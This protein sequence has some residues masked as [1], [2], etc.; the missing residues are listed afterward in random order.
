MV[1]H[2]SLVGKD[3]LP[4]Q[5]NQKALN[6]I[7]Q[8][9]RIAEQLGIS[10][11]TFRERLTQKIPLDQGNVLNDEAKEEGWSIPEGSKAA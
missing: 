5:E 7:R 11:E 3:G 6:D 4:F 8:Q 2:I 10:I 9:V 1:N